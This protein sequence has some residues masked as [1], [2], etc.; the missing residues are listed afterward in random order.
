MWDFGRGKL[1]HGVVPDWAESHRVAICR[2][3]FEPF[4]GRIMT[5]EPSA[6]TTAFTPD[7]VRVE[8]A[9]W[10]VE[11][12]PCAGCGFVFCECEYNASLPDRST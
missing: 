10:L 2:A 11:N 9:K 4:V 3:T 7:D 1:S 12:A 8:L 5:E 6:N